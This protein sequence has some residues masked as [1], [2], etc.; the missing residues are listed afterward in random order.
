MRYRFSKELDEMRRVSQSLDDLNRV[1]SQSQRLGLAAQNDF[2][3]IVGGLMETAEKTRYEMNQ[4][5]R[6]LQH[7]IDDLFQQMDSFGQSQRAMAE[8]LEQ[9]EELCQTTL[10]ALELQIM[11]ISKS[12]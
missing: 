4:V 7:R 12:L 9:H 11:R 1:I 3:N 10:K 2:M 6:A 5:M 8:R